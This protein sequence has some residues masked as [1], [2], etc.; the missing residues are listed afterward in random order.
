MAEIGRI[1]QKLEHYHHDTLRMK[2]LI[3]YSQYTQALDANCK[4]MEKSITEAIKDLGT[5]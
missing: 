4:N 1:N 3:N 2:E 5:Y